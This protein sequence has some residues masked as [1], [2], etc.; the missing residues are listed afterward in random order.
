MLVIAA[1]FWVIALLASICFDEPCD[2]NRER[3]YIIATVA[4][5]VVFVGS[6]LWSAVAVARRGGGR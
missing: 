2:L 6:T 4:F 3:V 1:V 5:G